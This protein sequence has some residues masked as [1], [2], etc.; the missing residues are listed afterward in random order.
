MR[1]RCA[2]SVRGR[3]CRVG[4]R[5]ADTAELAAEAARAD[6]VAA[7]F[8]GRR[9]SDASLAECSRGIARA[10]LAGGG[11]LEPSTPR[12]RRSRCTCAAAPTRARGSRSTCG[13]TRRA[14]RPRSRP[15]FP[16]TAWLSGGR[17]SAQR[18][19]RSCTRAHRVGRASRNTV[20]TSRVPGGLRR[21]RALPY[22]R[23]FA[24]LERAVGRAS[25][26]VD[27]A[28]LD[29]V[30]ARRRRHRAPARGARRA[31]AGRALRARGVAHRR[32]LTTFLRGAEPDVFELDG[33]RHCIEVRGVARRRLG[34]ARRLA[35]F[36]FRAA[37]ASN[38]SIGEAAGA[39]LELDAGFDAGDALRRLVRPGSLASAIPTVATGGDQAMTAPRPVARFARDRGRLE[40]LPLSVIQL[41]RASESARCSSGRA[42][43][44]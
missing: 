11:E 21:A 26:A 35:T 24:E 44:R 41:A 12:A 20:R 4:Q 1:T 8:S 42:C 15:E 19:A 37:L 2:A 27:G 32:A 9:R 3:R 23:S 31:A 28:P 38:G 14:S 33:G 25:I 29:V 16:A 6:A 30:G 13:I 22:L 36:A 40:R 34:R 43:S 18:R 10:V 17:S 7:R 5:L 39:A